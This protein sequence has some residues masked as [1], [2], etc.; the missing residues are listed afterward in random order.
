MVGSKQSK[1]RGADFE[2]RVRKDMTEKGWIVDKF[3]NNVE[4]DFPLETDF[5]DFVDKKKKEGIKVHGVMPQPH[6]IKKEGKLIQAKNKWAGT[7]RPMMMGAGFPDFVC[8]Q[9]SN[10]ERFGCSECRRVINVQ[11]ELGN[12]YEVI[13]VECKCNGWLSQIE[14][15][16]CRWLLNNNVFSK[17]L[18]AERTKPKNKIVIIYHDFKER[19]GKKNAK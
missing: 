17:I 5:A 19:Y 14:R 10:F 18:I 9:R 8:F 12:V 3:G 11:K 1:A 4:F 2:L 15:E 13:G 16:K 7:G 6:Y